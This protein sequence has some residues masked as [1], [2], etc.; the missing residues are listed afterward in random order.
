MEGDC[1]I[2]LLSHRSGREIFEVNSIILRLVETQHSLHTQDGS[3]YHRESHFQVKIL[4]NRNGITQKNRKYLNILPGTFRDV[5]RRRFMAR[6][7]ASRSG[8]FA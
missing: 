8:V 1:V 7:P 3:R 5:Y 6:L 2:Y 4:M